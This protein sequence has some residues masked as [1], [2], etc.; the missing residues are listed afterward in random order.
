M[1]LRARDRALCC[2]PGKRH[3]SMLGCWLVAGRA[4]G[5]LLAG[6]LA[7]CWQGCWHAAGRVA[8]MFPAGLLVCFWQGCWHVA[9]GGAGMLLAWCALLRPARGG[10]SDQRDSA[11]R[12]KR[13]T[14][15]SLARKVCDAA[16]SRRHTAKRS[17]RRTWRSFG[18]GMHG[19]DV[20]RG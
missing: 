16:L 19:A 15:R 18:S 7:C 13:S 8:S 2:L 1:P 11:K 14:R 17:T 12:S 10:E 5:M 6:L 3:W 20:T 4:A 9:G